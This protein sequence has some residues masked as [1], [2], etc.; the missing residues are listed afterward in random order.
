MTAF[1]VLRGCRG[2]VAGDWSSTERE[3]YSVK[4]RVLG[5]VVPGIARL[6][7]WCFLNDEKWGA[8]SKVGFLSQISGFDASLTHRGWHR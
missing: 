1:Y 4:H 2:S 8:K 6:L 7:L 3:I 5:T